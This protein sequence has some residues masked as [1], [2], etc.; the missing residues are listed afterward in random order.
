M[1]YFAKGRDERLF[2]RRLLQFA[3]PLATTIWRNEKIFAEVLRKHRFRIRDRA[4]YLFT[5]SMIC[6]DSL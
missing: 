2:T 1:S 5:M 6:Y 4:L 3:V